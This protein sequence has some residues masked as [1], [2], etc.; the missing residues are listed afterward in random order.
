MFQLI[1]QPMQ[2][3]MLTRDFCG[4]IATFDLHVVPIAAHIF[5]SRIKRYFK[6]LSTCH[7]MRVWESVLTA[8]TQCD[9]I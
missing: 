9:M 7:G 5:V 6:G 1:T 2:W 3:S 4:D 8:F